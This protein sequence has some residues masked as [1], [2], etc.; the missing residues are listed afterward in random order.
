MALLFGQCHLEV[1]RS[2]GMIHLEFGFPWLPAGQ[3]VFMD[4][5]SL[6]TGSLCQAFFR[7]SG[8]AT[9]VVRGKN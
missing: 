9:E 4:I 8:L 7:T 1:N 5:A 3:G 2:D 6:A